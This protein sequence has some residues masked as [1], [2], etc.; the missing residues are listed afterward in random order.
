MKTRVRWNR[1]TLA[2]AAIVGGMWYAAEAQ[3]N[4]AAHLITLITAAMGALSW[5]HARANLRGVSLRLVG[6][7][8]T[9]Q[10]ESKCIP[11]ELRAT[12][13]VSPCGLEV[14][15]IGA[16]TSVFVERVPSG[17]AVLVN[18]PPPARHAGGALR[19]MVRSVYPLGL[20]T[21]EGVMQ[22]SWVRRVHPKPGG[23]LPLP[24]ASAAWDRGAAALRQASRA[25]T[26]DEWHA[27]LARLGAEMAA[28]YELPSEED[29]FDWW[30]DR[31]PPFRTG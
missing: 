5:L 26:A 30:F 17:Q 21:A 7:R 28:A 24:A 13:A 31:L 29:P 8:P 18:L 2:L 9:A 14:L 15:V 23:D 16:E 25:R 20:F 22:T 12:G 19:I 4:G 10:N 11:V 1:H 3:S 6:G 27:A